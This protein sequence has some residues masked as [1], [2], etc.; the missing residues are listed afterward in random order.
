MS[1]DISWLPLSDRKNIPQVKVVYEKYTNQNYGGYY[2]TTKIVVVLHPDEC[3]NAIASTIAHE[4]RHHTQLVLNQRNVPSIAVPE[5]IFDNYP[6]AIRR[7]F[8]SS[9]SEMDALVY[10]NKIIKSHTA[11]QWLKAYVLP[12]TI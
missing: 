1:S 2:D 7:Y 9:I 3:N 12:N 10:Q 8:R 11:E 6:Q 5:D 4:F